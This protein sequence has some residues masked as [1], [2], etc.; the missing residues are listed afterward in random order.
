VLMCGAC[1]GMDQAKAMSHPMQQGLRICDMKAK[2]I[3]VCDS[4]TNVIIL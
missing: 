4:K 2:V 3:N 1:D